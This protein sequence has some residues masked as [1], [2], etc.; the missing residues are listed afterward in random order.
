MGRTKLTV[1]LVLILAGVPI[2][3]AAMLYASQYNIQRETYVIDSG[4]PTPATP[5]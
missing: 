3:A 2:A 1:I 5:H 4:R